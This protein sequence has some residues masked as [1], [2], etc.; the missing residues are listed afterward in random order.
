[1]SN[2]TSFAPVMAL[3]LI[4]GM[5]HATDADHV[6]AVTTIVARQ[7]TA[8]AAAAIGAAWGVGHT[9]TILLVGTGIIMFGWVISPRVG[10]STEL[11]VGLMLILLG[12]IN[13][14]SAVRDIRAAV[15]PNDRTRQTPLARV[16]IDVSDRLADISFGHR[17]R[18][19]SRSRGLGGCHA[20][21][22]HDHSFAE[23][24]DSLSAHFRTWND[25]R[26]DDD[27][28]H[29]AP[30][31]ARGAPVRADQ[32]RPPRGDECPQRCVRAI[33]RLPHWDRSRF[34]YWR[35]ELDSVVGGE[36]ALLSVIFAAEEETSKHLDV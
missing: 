18:H 13:L 24:G 27:D 1:M 19:R 12:G 8:R 31:C 34:V 7:R 2:T 23:L 3:G 30:V 21:R 6:M 36:S 4:L 16:S 11:T 14:S 29:R 25:R 28:G 22:A 35:S 20:A 33:H 15:V 9:L 10:L 26:D 17:R 5:R 32:R